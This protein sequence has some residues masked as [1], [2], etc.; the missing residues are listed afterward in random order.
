MLKNDFL[1][2]DLIKTNRRLTF[3]ILW[4]DGRSRYYGPDE[5]DYFMFVA[6]NGYEVISRSRMDIQTERL[7]LL[8]AV[9]NERSGTMVFSSNEKRD[10]AYN[11]FVRA[12]DEWQENVRAGRFGPKSQVVGYVKAQFLGNMLE[13]NVDP[14]PLVYKTMHAEGATYL[15]RVLDCCAEDSE[16]WV[17]GIAHP[18]SDFA[19]VSPPS[20][21]SD[22]PNLVMSLIE[23]QR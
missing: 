23:H 12:L 22:V 9:E 13:R 20:S 10:A 6:S 11:N 16:N 17:L 19:R 1:K 15:R 4:Q 14:F 3:D 7:W 5:G 2:F 21:E 8:G 18:L